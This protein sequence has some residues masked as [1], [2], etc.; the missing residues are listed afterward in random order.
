[1]HGQRHRGLVLFTERGEV[2]DVVFNTHSCFMDKVRYP[3]QLEVLIDVQ[4]LAPDVV[5]IG[6]HEEHVANG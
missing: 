4:F 5:A 3:L 1:M 2:C 6:V